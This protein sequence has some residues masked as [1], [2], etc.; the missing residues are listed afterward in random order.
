MSLV[1]CDCDF[2]PTLAQ[3]QAFK[4]QGG[5]YSIRYLDRAN[6]H[7]SKVVSIAEAADIKEAG[8]QLVLV[9]E[10]D[11]FVASP[12][13]PA[14]GVA[15]AQFCNEWIPTL[16]APSGA[17]VYYAID[18][19]Y[20]PVALPAAVKARC[21]AFYST[22]DKRWTPGAYAGGWVLEQL[23]NF[24]LIK[25]RWL[26]G[27]MGY[28]RSEQVLAAKECEI[29]QGLPFYSP[30]FGGNQIDPDTV[31]SDD[32]GAFTP[33]VVAPPAP[34]TIAEIQTWLN[35]AG[36]SPPLVVDGIAGNATVRAIKAFQAAHSLTADG[37]VGPLTQAALQSS[38]AVA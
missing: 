32:I 6:Y 29:A 7:T 9:Y 12:G 30:I 23:V 2:R 15:D 19:D 1:A 34:P 28:Y 5:K 33:N 8:L 22:L 37:I 17:A 27:S 26:T 25:K 13:T 10:L 11:G 14:M 35:T 20:G 3:Y 4:T 24:A 36:A 18:T 21:E 38:G 31:F 16:G